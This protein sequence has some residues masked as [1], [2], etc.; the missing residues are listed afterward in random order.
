M[1]KFKFSLEVGALYRKQIRHQLERSKDKLEYLHGGKVTIREEK[2]LLDSTF[3]VQGVGFPDTD[4]FKK[5]I[6]KWNKQINSICD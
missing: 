6:E 5:Q 2:R 4:E 3:Y 1:A